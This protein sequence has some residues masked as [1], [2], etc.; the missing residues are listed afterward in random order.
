M[1]IITF[2]LGLLKNP[3]IILAMVIAGAVFSAYQIVEGRGYDRGWAAREDEVQELTVERDRL[4]AEKQQ[5]Q[6]LHKQLMSESKAEN[7][8]IWE[9]L[10]NQLQTSQS[11]V[12]ALS[13]RIKNV[14]EFV[15][16]KADRECVVPDGFV[17]L[18]DL[19]TPAGDAASAAG[20]ADAPSGVALSEVGETVAGNYA[21]CEADRDR[22]RMWQSWYTR[23]KAWT[24]SLPDSLKPPVSAQDQ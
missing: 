18:H 14:R 6:A 7:E 22:L 13:E 9:D 20:D 19:P 5:E 17:R 2:L 11:K 1:T 23:W 3:R 4:V 15:S 12:K 10:R 21:A 8:L 16:E 24:D